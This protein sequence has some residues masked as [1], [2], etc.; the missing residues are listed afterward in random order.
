M[1]LH[2]PNKLY[3][4]LLF[5]LFFP[6]FLRAT[7][8]VGGEMNYS[9][10]G[11]NEY[12][13]SLTIFRDCYNGDPRAWF[14]DPASIGV[15]NAG[16]ELIFEI[17][18]PLMGNDTLAPVLSSECLVAPPDVCVHTTVYRAIVELPPITGGYQLAYQRCCRNQTIANIVNP[19]AT[20]ATFGVTI[21][22]PALLQCNSNP[23]FREWPPIYICAGEPIL[24]DQSAVDIDGDSIVYRLCTPLAGASQQFPQPQPPNPPPYREIVWRDPPYGVENMLN[25]FPG[26]A[27]LQIDAQTGL[28][29]GLPNT[30]GQFVVGICVEEYRDGQ[31][32]STTR[33]D[34]QY[35]V[36]QCGRTAAAFFAPDIYC[37]GLTVAFDNQSEGSTSFLWSFHQDGEQLGIS[38]E[39]SP[40]FTFPDSGLYAVTLVADPGEICSDTFTRKIQIHYPSLNVDFDWQRPTCSDSVRITARDRSTDSLS[41]IVWRRW[42]LD[43]GGY[44][45]GEPEPAF[46]VPAAEN[47]RLRLEV[48][49]ANGCR[50][51]RGV[52]IA[53]A[54]IRTNFDGDSAVVCRGAPIRLNPNYDPTYLYQWEENELISDPSEPDPLVSLE[55]SVTFSVRILD[56]LS[57]CSV[58]RELPVFVP[59][60]LGLSAPADTALCVTEWPL[61]VRTGEAVVSVV[62]AADAGLTDLIAAGDTA[63]VVPR[64]LE[65]YFVAA[66]DRFGCTE[67][68]SV[69]VQGNGIELELS[70]DRTLCAGDTLTVTAMPVRDQTLMYDWS[71]LESILDG[72]GTERIS[73]RPF[74]DTEYRLSVVNEFGCRFDTSVFV[75]FLDYVPPLSVQ[76][77]PDTLYAPGEVRLEATVDETYRYD[78]SPAVDLSD[79]FASTTFVFVEETSTFKLVVQDENGCKNQAA[80]TV[81]VYNPECVEPNIFVPTAFTPNGDN[82]NDVFLPRGLNI[83]EMYL[84]IYNRWG[85][86]VFQSTEPSRGW[87]GTYRSKELGP[88]VYGYYLEVGCA[89][90]QRFEKKGNVTLLR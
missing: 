26:A 81:V 56:T 42:T 6:F 89:N 71:P 83:E 77:D 32:I 63:W 3:V 2:V 72:W 50:Q 80:L 75:R 58:R 13:I 5:C 86:E 61:V 33:R 65:S 25:G 28:L 59:P 79:P 85:E 90:G 35:N 41:V 43:P 24:F 37:D 87:D 17:Q 82:I 78:W 48:E 67:T 20:G 74:E 16:N 14:D 49:T 54:V 68:D 18:I 84:I 66:S 40:T 12:E 45:S 9:C 88:D 31:L 29:T 60:P 22:E 44:V 36:G 11:N 8:I 38:R 21:S 69:R 10:L 53:A 64:G 52:D 39:A 70:P 46:H 47:Y 76:A 51:S 19:L 30:I 1:N 27:P 7:H 4:P 62:W 15:F 73:V 55:E 23:K 57:R 34:F